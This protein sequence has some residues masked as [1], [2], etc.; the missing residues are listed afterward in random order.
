M[1]IFSENIIKKLRKKDNKNENDLIRM[2]K[3]IYYCETYIFPFILTLICYAI[4]RL[5]IC[6]F[7]VFL[8]SKDFIVI[9]NIFRVLSYFSIIELWRE[10]VSYIVGGLNEVSQ[11]C[12][13]TYM[14]SPPVLHKSLRNY[15]D[16]L[17]SLSFKCKTIVNNKKYKIGFR[18][19]IFIAIVFY[20]TE[21]LIWGKLV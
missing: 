9:S 14:D 21:F 12:S 5:P 16:Y 18:V 17:S 4:I 15:Y 19:I 2:T 3:E 11:F 6:A 20:I 7:I 10:I 1:D 8:I 13:S